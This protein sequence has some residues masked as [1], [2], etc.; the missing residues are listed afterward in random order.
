M[1]EHNEQPMV[2]IPIM[3]LVKSGLERIEKQVDGF[4]TKFE[5]KLNDLSDTVGEIWE[6]QGKHYE[7][8]PNTPICRTIIIATKYWQLVLMGL[9][10]FMI[11]TAAGLTTAY[12]TLIKPKDNTVITDPAT[13]ENAIREGKNPKFRDGAVLKQYEKNYQEGIKSMNK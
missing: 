5:K 4:E 2:S 11:V 9:L 12:E 1:D 8:C 13:L 10:G 6:T 3:E 7:E